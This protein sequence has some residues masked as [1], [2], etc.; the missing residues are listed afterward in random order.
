MK[1][2]LIGY[3]K[4]GKTIEEV[5]ISKGHIISCRLDSSDFDP[6]ELANSDVAIEFTQPDAA[7]SNILKCYEANVPIIVGTTGWYD[8][9][10]V[11][12]KKARE[13]NKALFTATNFS[14][15]VNI[16]FHLNEKLAGIMNNF[17]EYKVHMDETHH[18]QKKDHPSGTA[19]TLAEG[20]INSLNRKKKYIGLL[21]GQEAEISA[22]DLQIISKR[23]PDIPGYHKVTYE[24]EIDEITISHNAKN[25]QGFA[26]GAVLA[27]EWIKG[28]TGVFG[29]NDLLNF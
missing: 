21:D 12:S 10:E 17:S 14:I 24:S 26:Q 20:I 1:I 6:S 15:G 27:A 2:A 18:L 4:M 5:A 9:Y 3:G 23:Q 7:V 25:R 28:K 16:L 13:E 29:M 19:V 8:K 11:L 22:F